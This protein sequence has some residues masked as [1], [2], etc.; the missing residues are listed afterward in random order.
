MDSIINPLMAARYLSTFDRDAANNEITLS[1]GFDFEEYV[2]ITKNTS[3]K[4]PTYPN[5]RPDRSPIELGSGFW[6]KGVDKNGEIALLQ[7]VRLY[8]L[9]TSFAEHL[10]SLRAYYMDVTLHASSHD[11]CKCV[12]P[13]AEIMTGKVAYHG[14]L[15]VRADFRGK[16]MPKIM[17]GIVFGVSYSLWMPDF[18][19]ALVPH[20][21]L[22]KGV[23]E[24]YE[25]L[26]YERGGAKLHLVEEGILDDDLIIWITGEELRNRIE[27]L[28]L[29]RERDGTAFRAM[30]TV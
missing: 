5:F 26:H 9:N 18:V 29:A 16:G 14:D 30:T 27:R 8:N 2:T 4:G 10:R 21:L 12:A 15:W 11:R 3:T 1:L 24:A 13:S 23:V 19:C 28:G 22:E 20:W 17:A 7:A 25:Y 6:V